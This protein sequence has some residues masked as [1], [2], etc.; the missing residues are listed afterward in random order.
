MMHF[1]CTNLTG[2]ATRAAL[3]VVIPVFASVVA[4][5]ALRAQTADTAH[6]QKTFF[7]RRD[8]AYTG[9]ALVGTGVVSIFDRRIAHYTQGPNV[10]GSQSRHDLANKIT[11]VNETTLTAAA[12]LGYGAGRLFHSP[13]VADVALH[14][15]ESL[16]L[17]SAISQL[18]RGPLGR[19][20]PSISPD[21]QYR[22]QI[23]KGFTQFNDRSFPSLHS[24]TAFAAAASLVGEIRE[25]DPGATWIAGPILYAA[26]AV[27]GVTRMYLNQHW[28]SDVVAG[29]FV[30][31]LIG[32]R[33]VSYAHSHHRNRFDAFLLGATVVPEGNGR[34]AIGYSTPSP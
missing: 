32:S 10:Q 6:V 25:R 11:K 15:T 30:G 23:G 26:A 16:V 13:M 12:I 28:A 7:V 31:T 17:T 8:L 29:A 21:D 27:P 1:P 5:L 14:T 24:A 19:E 33:V 9:A 20:R 2:R 34:V 22:F 18:I 3:L 4:P